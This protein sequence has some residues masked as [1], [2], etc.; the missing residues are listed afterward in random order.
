MAVSLCNCLTHIIEIAALLDDLSANINAYVANCHVSWSSCEVLDLVWQP[1]AKRTSIAL[2]YLLR[3]RLITAFQDLTEKDLAVPSCILPAR[4]LC[5]V[6]RKLREANGIGIDRAIP[7][8]QHG[9]S[10]HECILSVHFQLK[11]YAL[12]VHHSVQD[13][14]RNIHHIQTSYRRKINPLTSFLFHQ[15]LPRAD[16]EQIPLVHW[17][18]AEVF[19]Y[20]LA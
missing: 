2:L 4:T 16:H 12:Q 1:I 3:S 6:V 9:V 14:T 19:P 15:E 20:S 13:L 10:L 18:Y 5:D 17:Q 11:R 8:D 7:L